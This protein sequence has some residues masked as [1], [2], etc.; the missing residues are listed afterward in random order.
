[1]EKGAGLATVSTQIS[2]G[3]VLTCSAQVVIPAV[4][5]AVCRTRLGAHS[6]QRTWWMQVCLIW[7]LKQAI[8]P[9]LEPRL[10]IPRQRGKSQPQPLWRVSSG[11]IWTEGLAI[12]PGSCAVQWHLRGEAGRADYPQSK[13]SA[14]HRA[15]PRHCSRGI[16][17]SRGWG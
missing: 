4:A 14:G 2:A 17:H 5:L 9:A 7:I 8:L 6:D 11:P 13:A 12:T 16:I 15:F 10:P 1:M 3:R